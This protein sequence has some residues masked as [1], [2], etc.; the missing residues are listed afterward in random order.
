MLLLPLAAEAETKSGSD[1]MFNIGYLI[2]K[3][4]DL[5]QYVL[6]FLENLFGGTGDKNF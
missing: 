3:F 1:K 2:E 5:L 6:N 4:S